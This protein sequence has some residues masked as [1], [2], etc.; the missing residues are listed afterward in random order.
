MHLRSVKYYDQNAARLAQQY[1]SAEVTGL[2][3]L[4]GRWLPSG[5]DLLEIGC[6]AGRDA[7]FMASHG[8]KVVACDASE[9]ML[10]Y[11][12]DYLQKVEESDSV[13]L[14][15]AEFPLPTNHSLLSR[16]FD[17]VIAMA[18]LMHIPEN[19]LFNFAY[20]SSM[21]HQQPGKPALGI[22]SRE[23]ALLLLATD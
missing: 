16:R 23:M 15:Q 5:G 1:H 17:S 10:Q 4:L 18:M 21:A 11:S 9:S 14:L 19:E 3:T 12:R 13:S 7:A 8:C 6:G 20:Q 22:N 2:H